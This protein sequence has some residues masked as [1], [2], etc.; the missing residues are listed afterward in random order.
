V[1]TT[2][3]AYV[4]AR[5]RLRRAGIDD[6]NFEAELLLRHALG[7][8]QNRGALLTRLAE[9]SDLAD[10]ALASYEALMARR[11]ARE[12]SAY[13]L[14]RREFAHLDLEVT[15]A[16]LIPRPET[17]TVAEQAIRLARELRKHDQRSPD[18]ALVIADVGTGSGAIALTLARAL[19]D[20]TVIATDVS[21]E[22]LEVAQ[23]NAA[24]HA[25]EGRIVFLRG[26]LLAPLTQRID[27]LVANLPY[28]M[29]SDLAAAQ[30]EVRDFEPSLALDGGPDGLDLI[31]RLLAEA[32]DRLRHPAVVVLEIGADQAETSR[33]AATDAWPHAH[34]SVVND[35]AGR[36]R[37]LIVQT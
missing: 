12:P 28:V 13:I 4:A 30:P 31:R 23:R 11:L 33:L 16:V 19:P 26:D 5:N 7:L 18:E 20:A 10:A 29:S 15:R 37:V 2:R 34:V 25:L 1:I 35:L 24:R 27:V 36:A 6:A 14:G 22:A 3:E 8:G 32:R 17:E 21:P 9:P